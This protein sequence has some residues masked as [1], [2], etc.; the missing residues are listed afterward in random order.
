M[1]NDEKKILIETVPVD[2]E[3]EMLLDVISE[4]Q[5]NI[6]VYVSE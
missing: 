3:L 2:E 6:E 1:T 4:K 5:A